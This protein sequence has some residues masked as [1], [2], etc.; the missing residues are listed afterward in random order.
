MRITCVAL[1]QDDGLGAGWRLWVVSQCC[2]PGL[3]VVLTCGNALSLFF[4]MKNV[5]SAVRAEREG[6]STEIKL[7]LRSN[8]RRQGRWVIASGTEVMQLLFN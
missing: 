1:L 6:G 2:Q 5:S 4:F 7:S 8:I 3:E